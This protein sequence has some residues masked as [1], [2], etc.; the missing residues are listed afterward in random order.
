[1]Q[2]N[3]GVYKSLQ[4]MM[5]NINIKRIYILELKTSQ[6]CTFSFSETSFQSLECVR[7]RL[8]VSSRNWTTP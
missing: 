8:L 5:Q 1:M 7:R 2:Y 3:T 4:N 6:I